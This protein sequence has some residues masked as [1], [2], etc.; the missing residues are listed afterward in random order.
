MEAA[1]RFG[2]A[3]ARLVGDAAVFRRG[4]GA[5]AL[6]APA[7]VAFGSTSSAGGTE[8]TAEPAARL[9]RDVAV[10][11]RGLAAPGELALSP[12]VLLFLAI[13]LGDTIW[14]AYFKWMTQ[15][16]LSNLLIIPIS[17]VSFQTRR[18][19]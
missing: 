2:L 6:A 10:R 1:F 9:A 13:R 12:S 18:S 14:N 15:T 8:G 7:R 3:G 19:E 17:I 4:F 16:A 11:G 5:A